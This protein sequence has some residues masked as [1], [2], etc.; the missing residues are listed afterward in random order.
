[1]RLALRLPLFMCVISFATICF[2]PAARLLWFRHV[3]QG[4][5]PP[6]EPEWDGGN[7]ALFVSPRLAG[8]TLMLV[9]QRAGSVPGSVPGGAA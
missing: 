2:P 9:G 3:N 4:L 1:M 5:L 8:S 6:A 7:I